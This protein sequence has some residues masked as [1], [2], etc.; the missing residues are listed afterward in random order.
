MR[1][2]MMGST[3]LRNGTTRKRG[4]EG[5]GLGEGGMGE[6]RRVGSRFYEG[7]EEK[8]DVVGLNS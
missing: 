7:V 1:R 5:G 3:K 2:E 6:T 8:R 4:R